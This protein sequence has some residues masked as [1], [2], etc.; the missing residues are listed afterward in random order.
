MSE[1]V[2]SSEQFVYGVCQRSFLSLWSYIN[3][4]GKAPNKE[5]C[6]IL[7]VCDPHVIVISVKDVELK[8]TGDVEINSDRWQRKAIEES[9]KQ[10]SGA[11]RWL[12]TAVEVIAKDGEKGLP[13]PPKKGRIYHRIAIAFGGRRE[14]PIV[15]YS[16]ENDSF[17]HIFDE[18]SFYLLLR[19][20]DTISD[21]IQYLSSKEKMPIQVF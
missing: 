2:N 7:V 21:F 3:P 5:L 19:H 12:D 15:T 13:L 20:L 18:R 1:G 10:I 16:S 14:I 11:I 17:V 4:Q 8:K 9:R 6:D